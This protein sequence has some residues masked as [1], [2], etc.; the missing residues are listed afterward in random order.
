MP[1]GNNRRLLTLALAL[2]AAS[3]AVQA[4]TV[5]LHLK[6]GDRLAGTLVAEDTN[7]VVIT[8]TW[9]RDLPVPVSEIGSREALPAAATNPPVTGPMLARLGTNA[10]APPVPESAPHPAAARAKHW[11]G[12]VRLGADYILSAT[13]QQLYYGRLKLAYEQA[14]ASNPKEFFRNSFDLSGNYGRTEGVISANSVDAG[15]QANLDIGKRFFL[16]NLLGTGYDKIRKIDLRYEI[17]PGLGYHLLA[18]ST[19][20]LMDLETGV[21]YQVQYRADNTTTKNFYPR[22]AEDLTWKVNHHLSFNE[23]FEIF[24]AVATADFRMRFE[25][26]LSYSLWLNLALNF[27]VLDLYDSLPAAGVP[28]NDLQIRSSIGLKF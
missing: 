23:K 8:T 9:A 21:D 6:N 20:L 5:I 16:Y 13:D 14:Y 11:T 17:G 10:A 15:D 22:L 28:D 24:P 19:N 27:T 1:P 18:N 3:A 12:E 2:L 26:T 4:E 25:S 7:R